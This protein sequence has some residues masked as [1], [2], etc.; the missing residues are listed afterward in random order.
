M[1]TNDARASDY[2]LAVG[3][4]LIDAGNPGSLGDLDMTPADIGNYGG[5]HPYVDGG[6]PDYP[7][8]VQLAVPYSAPLNGTM[9]VAGRGRV[10]PGN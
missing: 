9:R 3:S 8:A 2:H 6:V 7:F 1:V 4:N 5:Q 10:G